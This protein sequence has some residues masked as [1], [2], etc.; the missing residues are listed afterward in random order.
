MRAAG[1]A[2]QVLVDFVV[3]ANGDVLR[4][5]A[6]RSTRREFEDPAVAA[7]SKWKFAAGR[8]G[9]V[10]VATR[11]QVPMVFNLGGGP[12]PELPATTPVEKRSGEGGAQLESFMV[13]VTKP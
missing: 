1:I 6:V 3:D 5:V 10:E 12:V 2:G 8:K 11:M 7:V 9:G 13:L 4:A